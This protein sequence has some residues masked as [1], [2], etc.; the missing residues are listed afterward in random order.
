MPAASKRLRAALERQSMLAMPS[1]YE[2]IG[3]RLDPREA[4][5]RYRSGRET[6]EKGGLPGVRRRRQP[7]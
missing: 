1:A 6:A 4:E 5:A 2:P 7:R 3:A